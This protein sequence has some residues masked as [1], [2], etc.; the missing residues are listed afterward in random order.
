MVRNIFR[1]IVLITLIVF[2]CTV[3]S[4]IIKLNKEHE[5]KIRI[6]YDRAVG[7]YKEVWIE[8]GG[9]V[10]L[11]NLSTNDD[12]Y[13]YSGWFNEDDKFVYGPL[14]ATENIKLKENYY[15]KNATNLTWVNVIL[16][17]GQPDFTYVFQFSVE[18][19][20][21]MDPVKEGYKFNGWINPANGYQV[22]EGD[23]RNNLTIKAQ[24]V[25]E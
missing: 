22:N 1:T 8:K 19:K 23:P 5:G 16:D 6:V 18:L 24:W 14:V 4:R 13:I 17:N 10:P 21:P 25:Q 7:G 11:E 3:G 9:I 20:L 15:Y 2:S 12:N